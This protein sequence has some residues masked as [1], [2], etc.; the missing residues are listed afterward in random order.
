MHATLNLRWRY[1]DIFGDVIKM[2]RLAG[3]VRVTRG[4]RLNLYMHIE[5][6]KNHTL[7]YQYIHTPL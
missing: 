4:K 7:G 2:S 3:V 5:R 1:V 6:D